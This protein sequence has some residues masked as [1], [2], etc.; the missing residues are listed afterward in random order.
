MNITNQAYNKA[1]DAIRAC[2]K[3][4]GLYARLA[5][6]SDLGAIR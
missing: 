3:P 4:T 1:I 2:S 5:G 6:L